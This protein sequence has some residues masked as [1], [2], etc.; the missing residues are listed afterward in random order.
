[1][2]NISWG[3]ASTQECAYPTWGH[4]SGQLT[5]IA[6]V[7]GFFVVAGCLLAVC[8]RKAIRQRVLQYQYGIASASFLAAATMTGIY[9]L[10]L[11]IFAQRAIFLYVD[12]I[13]FA[14]EILV[15]LVIAVDTCLK[16]AYASSEGVKQVMRHALSGRL[17]VDSALACGVAT[18]LVQSGGK[19]T[20]WSFSC[21]ST[22][23]AMGSVKVLARAD[24][25]DFQRQ[26][27]YAA[28][29]ALLALIGW[30]AALMT[31][32]ILGPAN[33]DRQLDYL[34]GSKHAWSLDE[35]ASF[36]VWL[37]FLAGS[38]ARKPASLM[39]QILGICGILMAMLHVVLRIVPVGLD[40][41]TGRSAFGEAYSTERRKSSQSSR[42]DST[43]GHVIITGSPTALT[44]WDFVF[45]YYHPNH[46]VDDHDF[47]KRA[48]DIIVFLENTDVLFQLSRLLGSPEAAGF[49]SK[50]FL[51]QGEAF[52]PE[53]LRK[54]AVHSSRHIVVLPDV[55]T[56]NSVRD[57]EVNVM[58]VFAFSSMSVDLRVTCL[59]HGAEHHE[60]VISWTTPN[61]ILVSLDGMKMSILG[62]ASNLS[63]ASAFI[64]NLCKSRSEI[65]QSPHKPPWM[66]YYE[67]SLDMELYE[68]PLS[69]MYNYCFFS[70]VY[71]DIFI[72]S[73]GNA[74]LI[75]L[76]DTSKLG[77]ITSRNKRN[78]REVVIN[79]GPEFQLNVRD[80]K[81]HGVFIAAEASKII[82]LQQ[83]ET[84][85]IGRDRK[86]K[87]F[88][89]FSQDQS[90]MM[91]RK[92]VPE[93]RHSASI[94]EDK[95][96]VIK[97]LEDKPL[98]E[99]LEVDDVSSH[100]S[101]GEAELE[102]EV[103]AAAIELKR[104]Y[105]ARV[106]ETEAVYEKFMTKVKTR[107]MKA[108]ANPE[109]ICE[110]TNTKPYQRKFVK[111]KIQKTEDDVNPEEEE[112][113]DEMGPKNEK[114]TLMPKAD[115]MILEKAEELENVGRIV[116]G[117]ALAAK[118]EIKPNA[119]Q[120]KRGGHILLCVV[121]DTDVSSTAERNF[122]MEPP[123]FGLE[124][125]MKALRD[126][127]LEMLPGAQPPVVLLSEVLPADWHDIMNM[128]K[129][130]YVPGN[131]M[132]LKDLE[133]AGFRSAH[134]IVVVR[135]HNGILDNVHRVS[136]GRMVL[137]AH[138][139]HNYFGSTLVRPI[140]TD[141]AY[142]ATCEMLPKIG[143]EVEAGPI[144]KK[145]L[146]GPKAGIPAALQKFINK[147]DKS[148]SS[149]GFISNF[150]TGN[151]EEKPEDSEVMDIAYQPRFLA[152]QMY[153][154]SFVSSMVANSMHSSSL[155]TIV[156]ALIEAPMF[157]LDVPE[158]WEKS[159]Y[160]D[161]SLWLM[162]D[163]GL[164]AL[165]IY[166]SALAAKA[167][168][169]GESLPNLATPTHHFMLTSP[170]GTKTILIKSDR[171]L[172]VACGLKNS[173]VKKTKLIKHLGKN[174]M[175]AADVK[176]SR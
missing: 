47:E 81:T 63:G 144:L 167:A 61:V 118:G 30:A 70:E 175:H 123:V 64:C 46:F 20:W 28:V 96:T 155:V 164:L 1:M 109:L 56:S 85:L 160:M 106:A 138:M 24:A 102:E 103:P 114:T 148:R 65:E 15:T 14:I 45:E 19:K 108:G 134:S 146:A 162:R 99:P 147:K 43:E 90:A 78:R 4:V 161:F 71:E 91:G 29:Y 80:G 173:P 69:K 83:G 87:G 39:G 77:S 49:R 122:I 172:V 17:L 93:L 143:V 170:H 6:A 33:G 120:L 119:A 131:P 41:I 11:L 100:G 159:K 124:Y 23:N 116:A 110:V 22:L 55:T 176:A 5:I 133:S 51:L 152:G 135:T 174:L 165:G 113:A 94:V 137:A 139:I 25:M 7:Y 75:G 127:R 107:L 98:E 154:H 84:I 59:L 3:C 168:K 18:L 158:A 10:Q 58:R 171:I 48:S 150:Y 76:T 54:A 31:F 125:F 111:P 67:Q 8:A 104:Q 166:R 38:C 136:D 60:S 2:V 72:R 13:L 156:E 101:D 53:H 163:R 92:V 34:P 129:V 157:M 74:V 132:R 35:S 151:T 68:V 42:N 37:F 82:Q 57:D 44:V 149:S 50:V 26:I 16:V 97:P 73:R 62:K 95:P 36:S 117:M 153:H 128:P 89:R 52:S 145:P 27:V 115:R 21:L 40:L 130:F 140:I 12:P 142:L 86:P 66:Y 112:E 88:N 169:T 32:E 9:T 79:P 105:Q 126:R 121:G 141:H